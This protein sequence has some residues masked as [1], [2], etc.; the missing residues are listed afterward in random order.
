MP[1]NKEYRCLVPLL[2]IAILLEIAVSLCAAIPPTQTLKGQ[3]LEDKNAPIAGAACTLVGPGLPEEG[4]S[5]ATGE[6]GGFEFTGL[7]PGSYDLTCA[8][9]RYE[10]LIQKDIGIAE[11]QSPFIQVVLPREIIVRQK[12]EVKEK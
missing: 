10:P 12:V 11:G 8:A 7:T 5:Q 1:R 3:V 6:N 4:R 2:T 9:L